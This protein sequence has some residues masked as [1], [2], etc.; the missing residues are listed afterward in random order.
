MDRRVEAQ[1]RL[2]PLQGGAAL[3]VEGRVLQHRIWKEL[4]GS[5][6]QHR[7]RH[8]VDRRARVVRLEVE[9]A[10]STS[11]REALHEWPVPVVLRIEL[12]LEP[13]VV[14]QPGEGIA[15]RRDDEPERAV[16]APD[17][18]TERKVVL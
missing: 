2:L 6:I 17:G 5:A 3:A 9:D 15:A 12:Q 7:V 13:R 11:C 4:D 10:N 18:C 1:P 14:L 16:L 8:D